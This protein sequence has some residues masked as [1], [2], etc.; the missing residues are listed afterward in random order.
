MEGV[1][2]EEEDKDEE[3]EKLRKAMT[4]SQ[5]WLFYDSALTDR[6][7]VRDL[8][9]SRQEE[10]IYDAIRKKERRL[11]RVLMPIALLIGTVPVILLSEYLEPKKPITDLPQRIKTLT[12]TLNQSARTIRIIEDEVS[13]RQELLERLRRDQELVTSLASLNQPQA[14]AVAQALRV[15]LK[16]EEREIWW[17]K[18]VENFVFA[19]LGAF[20][21]LGLDWLIRRLRGRIR[22]PPQAA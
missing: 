7:N 16:K 9:R 5:G 4:P 21:A 12:D 22:Q 19:A 2:A 1:M 10:R 15:E 14:E 3:L 13:Q 6:A 11:D 8:L 18:Q 20:L 17:S